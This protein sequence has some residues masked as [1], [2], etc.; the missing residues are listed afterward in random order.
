MSSSNKLNCITKFLCK[1]H[2]RAQITQHV[3]LT[4]SESLAELLEWMVQALLLHGHDS[5]SDALA[6]AVI[7]HR[8]PT[9]IFRRLLYY[10]EGHQMACGLKKRIPLNISH[11]LHDAESSLGLLLN[12]RQI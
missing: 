5:L 10:I 4:A 3:I 8:K 6:W 7:G 1:W 12:Q 11:I 9:S 2:F